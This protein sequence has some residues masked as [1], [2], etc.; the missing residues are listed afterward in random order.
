MFGTGWVGGSFR[1]AL[2]R[3]LKRK[4]KKQVKR[5]KKEMGWKR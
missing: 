1:A 5:F 3:F 4:A 2:G